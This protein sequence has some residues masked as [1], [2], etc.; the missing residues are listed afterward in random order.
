MTTASEAAGAVPGGPGR[1]RGQDHGR[2][3]LEDYEVIE[4]R[5]LAGLLAHGRI[6]HRYN[7]SRTTV[8]SIIHRHTWSHL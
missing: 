3:K 6:A 1:A 8:L 5:A 2:A 4:I 7:V